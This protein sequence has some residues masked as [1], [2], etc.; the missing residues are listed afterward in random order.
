MPRVLVVGDVI[1][2]VIVVPHGPIRPDTDTVSD[3]RSTAGGSA[4]NTASWLGQ[5]GVEVEFVGMVGKADLARHSAELAA[6]GVTPH[7]QGHPTLPTGAI[8]ILVDGDSR[9]MLTERGANDFL[10]LDAIDLAGFDLLHLTG[11]SLFTRP[12]AA[13]V[14]ALIERARAGGLEVCVDPGSAGFLRDFGV[15]RF[16]TA[17]AGATILV[18]NLEE[19]KVLTGAESPDEVARALTALFPVVAVTLDRAGV[20]V[21]LAGGSVTSVQAQSALVV[22]PTGAGDAFT[23][24]FLAELLTTEDPE[25]AADAG[26]R[27]AATAVSSLGARPPL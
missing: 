1:D 18:P 26:C 19:G 14:T 10:D 2:D 21:A 6:H 3:I 16:L 9:S 27:I 12:D 13:P 17:I 5:L 15:E 4:G 22:D 20:V 8:V 25:R 24:G 7:L 23:A 11:Y